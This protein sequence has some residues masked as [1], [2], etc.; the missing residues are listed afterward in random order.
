MVTLQRWVKMKLKLKIEVLD[1]S[2][3]EHEKQNNML[4][5]DKSDFIQGKG[6]LISSIY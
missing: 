4:K 5:N 1:R 2:V 6:A 3:A